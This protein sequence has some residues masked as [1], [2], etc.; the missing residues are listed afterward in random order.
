MFFELFSIVVV[1][2]NPL[3]TTTTNTSSDQLPYE[4]S[5]QNSAQTTCATSRNQTSADLL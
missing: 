4:I 3:F 2:E 1:A 5:V